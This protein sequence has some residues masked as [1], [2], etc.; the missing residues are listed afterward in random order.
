MHWSRSDTL[1]LAL[2]N[3][4]YCQ[5]TG[6]RFMEATLKAQPCACVLRTVFRICHARFHECAVKERNLGRTLIE[7]FATEGVCTCGRR[8]EEYAADFCLVSRR[9]LADDEYRL[10]KYFFIYGAGSKLCMER[11]G[12]SRG[13]FYRVL[14]RI[15]AK[16]G[17]VFRET[18]PYALF[19][20]DEYFYGNRRR[21]TR[22]IPAPRVR[23]M[24]PRRLAFPIPM[25]RTA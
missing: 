9:A 23:R 8:E 1:A 2:D 10:F 16:L 24:P 17:R 12:M 4:T 19:P 20:V 22:A 14:Y 18:Q 6:L 7:P 11:L 25:A 15:E 3:C 5:G 21:D 13:Q